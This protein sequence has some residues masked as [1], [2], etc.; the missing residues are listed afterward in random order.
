M[1]LPGPEPLW[2]LL[3]LLGCP[4]PL[5][6][7][8]KRLLSNDGPLLEPLR[9]ELPEDWAGLGGLEEEVGKAPGGEV[10]PPEGRPDADPR[11]GFGPGAWWSGCGTSWYLWGKGGVRSIR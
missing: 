5:V 11:G 8:P 3:P 6:K 7:L 4:P 10:C 1:L 2:V 9:L